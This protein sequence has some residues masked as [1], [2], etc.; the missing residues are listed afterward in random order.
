MQRALRTRSWLQTLQRSP[1]ATSSG[2]DMSALASKV[3]KL[4]NIQ[5]ETLASLKVRHAEQR[6][7]RRPQF[8]TRPCCAPVIVKHTQLLSAPTKQFTSLEV[9][10]LNKF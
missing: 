8:L 10:G 6:R 2:D 3:D 1:A 4:T 5:E 7:H 9:Q